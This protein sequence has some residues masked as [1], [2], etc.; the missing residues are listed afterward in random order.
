MVNEWEEFKAYT[1]PPVYAANSKRDTTYLGRFTYD[2]IEEYKGMG[3][4]LTILAR[5]YLFHDRDGNPLEGNHYDRV[6]YA[7]NALKAWC[8]VP[9]KQKSPEPTVDFRELSA[10]FPE[11]VNRRGEGWYYRHVRGIIRF[12]KQNPDLVDKRSYERCMNLSKGFMV[13]W[14]KKAKQ[15]QV[16]IFALNTKSG[17]TLRFDDILADALA[18]GALRNPQIALPPELVQR[19]AEA[20]PKGVPTTVLPILAQYY[21]ANRRE[22]TDW[23]VLPVANFNA[24]FG[25]TS[26]EKKWLAAIP[27]DVLEREQ[28]SGVCRFRMCSGVS[29]ILCKVRTMA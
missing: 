3:R 10:D 14:K 8:S 26:F 25:T 6:E 17:W 12:V 5:G 4:I 23:V 19:L 22:D 18:M 2:M 15:L 9:D 29:Q 7:R 28:Y 1:D 16:P 20:T 13:H 27:K 11:L 24:Y 21:I